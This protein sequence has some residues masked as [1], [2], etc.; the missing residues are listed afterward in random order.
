MSAAANAAAAAARRRGQLAA[1]HVA[2]QQLGMDDDTYRAMLVRVSGTCGLS[3][4]SA[5]DLNDRQR[6]AVLDELRHLGAAV[7]ARSKARGI[8]RYPGKPANFERMPDMVRKIEALLADMRLSWSYADAIA[9]R[10]FGVARVA[11]CRREDQLRAIIA[12]LHVEQEKRELGAR[13]DELQQQ[14]GW[15]D[16][17]IESRFNVKPRDW[18][19]NRA[20]L[21]VVYETLAGL[22]SDGGH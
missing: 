5:A 14:L 4:R 11:W 8:G 21:S 17:T 22:V 12:A 1:I 18:R 19:R 10:M 15:T 20:A 16:E 7:P 3:V 13:I 6:A 9:K 2:A